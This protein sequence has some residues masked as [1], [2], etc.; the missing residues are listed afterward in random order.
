MEIQGLLLHLQSPAICLYNET[1]N[2][3]Y[4]Y[5]SHFWKFHFNIILL[6]TPTSSKLSLFIR[7][8]HKSPVKT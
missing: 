8:R 7:S 4:A 3:V 2:P 5:A 6:Y 1:D